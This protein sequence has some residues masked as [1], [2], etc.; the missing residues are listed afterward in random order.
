VPCVVRAQDDRHVRVSCS[1]GWRAIR[2]DSGGRARR[3]AIEEQDGAWRVGWA[4]PRAVSSCAARTQSQRAVSRRLWRLK[5]R[6]AGYRVPVASVTRSRLEIVRPS[7]SNARCGCGPWRDFERGAQ[8]RVRLL[9]HDAKRRQARQGISADRSRRA[10]RPASG[11]A[12]PPAGGVVLPDPFGPRI[13][14]SEPRTISSET[15]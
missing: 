14:S 4:A 9:R 13:P 5:P 6:S 15:P 1:R 2:A 10:A 12:C 8:R 11:E 7:I 3:W